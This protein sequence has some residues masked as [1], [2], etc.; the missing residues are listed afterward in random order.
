MASAG[1]DGNILIWVPAEHQ[2]HGS[3]GDDA[4]GDKETWRVKH[5]CRGMGSEIY[6]LAWSPDGQFILS[7]SMDNIARIYNTSTGRLC[8]SSFGTKIANTV[9]VFVFDKSQ[10]IVISCKV[11]HGTRSTNISQHN[12]RIARYIYTHSRQKKGNL[13]CITK[14]H[15]WIYQEDESPRALQL[16]QTLGEQILAE[17]RLLQRR[18]EISH[19]AEHHRFRR[20]LAR[21]RV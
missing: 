17:H 4:M 2:D 7:G 9:Q 20:C 15:E 6:D 8:A 3:F 12:R 21:L 13:R 5:M 11:L 18:W 1:D 10:N 14:L 16:H 19:M